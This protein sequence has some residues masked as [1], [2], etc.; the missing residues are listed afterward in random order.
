MIYV[1]ITISELRLPAPTIL[2]GRSS[3]LNDCWNIIADFW[4]DV[5]YFFVLTYRLF[6]PVHTVRASHFKS[7]P[8]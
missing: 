3:H 8:L 6:P 5:K 4:G 2:C 7:L 1:L